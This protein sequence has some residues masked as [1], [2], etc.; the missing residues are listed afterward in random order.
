M[1]NAETPIKPATSAP[2]EPAVHSSDLVGMLGEFTAASGHVC[3]CR[4][5]G[6]E[7][8]ILEI[9]YVSPRTGQKFSGAYIGMNEF[10]PDKH[11]NRSA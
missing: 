2:S 11:P 1:I 4:V 6:Q 3:Q 10:R 7:R 9:E 8:G 5:I